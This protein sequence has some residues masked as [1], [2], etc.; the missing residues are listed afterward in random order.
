MR[1]TLNSRVVRGLTA[2]KKE[3]LSGLGTKDLRTPASDISNYFNNVI[4]FVEVNPS[5]C[6]W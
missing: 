4:F 5:A 1:L 3:G 2:N 6:R